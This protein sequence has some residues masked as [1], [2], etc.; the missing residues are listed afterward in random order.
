[1]PANQALLDGRGWFRTSD[2]SRVKRGERLRHTRPEPGRGQDRHAAAPR[3]RWDTYMN[4][5]DPCE[6]IITA[7]DRDWLADLCRQLIDAQLA[8]SAHVIHPVTSIYRWN[9]AINEATEARAFL[10][11]RRDKGGRR[12]RVRGRTSPVPGA[13][14]HGASHHRRQSRLPRLG[15]R[16]DSR[17]RFEHE[18]TA[19]REER[20]LFLRRTALSYSARELGLMASA[21]ARIKQPRASA[22][23]S[24]RR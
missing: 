22:S 2:L 7:P 12:S 20:S 14:H 15:P 19:T 10:R 16:R 9:R 6:V 5:D 3:H 4:T 13:K 17:Q 18:M 24:A 21:A 11:S 8:A 23:A 1:M